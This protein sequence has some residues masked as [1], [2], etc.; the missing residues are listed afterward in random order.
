MGKLS[1]TR[2]ITLYGMLTA[3]YVVLSFV[4]IP[5]PGINGKIA[6]SGLPVIFAAT[7]LGL[8]DGLAV[9]LLGSFLMQ[10]MQYG[11]QVTTVIWLIPPLVRALVIGIAS[12]IFK[13]KKDKLSNH[14]IIYFITSLL[15]G[16]LVTSANTLAIWLDGII[17]GYDSSI[18]FL[19][20]VFRF[21]TS[22]ITTVVLTLICYPIC[23]QIEKGFLDPNTS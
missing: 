4:S 14:K 9:A 8:F 13:A 20:T 19:S 6:F 16:L 18:I 2:R 23:R 10:V 22:L 3:L 17:L 11:I 15:A 7:S 21:V 1:I 5:L 12:E